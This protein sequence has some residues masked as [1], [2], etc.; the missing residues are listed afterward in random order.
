MK[1]LREVQP[2][3]TATVKKVHGDRAV[4]QRLM[5]MGIIKGAEIAV[6]KMAPL[7]DPIEVTLRGYELTLRKQEAE[8]IEVLAL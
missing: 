4:H 6:R 5:D 8:S 2:G 3:Q 1:T 7:G